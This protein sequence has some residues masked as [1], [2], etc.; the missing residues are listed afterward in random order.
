MQNKFHLK[1]LAWKGA[2]ELAGNRQPGADARGLRE[3]AVAGKLTVPE[4]RTRPVAA[5]PRSKL[6]SAARLQGELS[7]SPN[8]A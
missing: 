5:A 1:D 2:D 6:N 7:L 4:R 3:Q 8:P